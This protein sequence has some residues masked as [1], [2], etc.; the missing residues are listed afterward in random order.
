LRVKLTPVFTPFLALAQTNQELV[1]MAGLNSPD[2]FVGW[3]RNGEIYQAFKNPQLDHTELSR[4]AYEYLSERNK[5][6]LYWPFVL[7]PLGFIS[8]KSDN[9]YAVF[10]TN[11]KNINHVKVKAYIKEAGIY[12]YWQQHGYPPQCLP[13]GEDDY[14]CD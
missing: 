10:R 4:S 9:D 14:E 13:L 1:F 5:K 8:A 7:R 6:I 12:D 3:H 2:L 11:H